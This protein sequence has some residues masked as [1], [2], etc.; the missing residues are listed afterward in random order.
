MCA[1]VLDLYTSRCLH[2]FSEPSGANR[3]DAVIADSYR[4]RICYFAPNPNCAYP[5]SKILIAVTESN[6][7]GGNQVHMRVL[8]AERSDIARPTYGVAR[9]QFDRIGAAC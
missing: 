5:C 3:K 9:E 2:C 6:T 8:P 7:A 1:R 4:V